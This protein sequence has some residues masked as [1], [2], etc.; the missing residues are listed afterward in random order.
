MLKTILLITLY[1]TMTSNV[2]EEKVV[3]MRKE[4][5]TYNDLKKLK[6]YR[7]VEL[8]NNLLCEKGKH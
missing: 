5:F 7:S 8:K 3:C 1:T 2:G 4:N 6:K